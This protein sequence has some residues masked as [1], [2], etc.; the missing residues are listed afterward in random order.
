MYLFGVIRYVTVRGA[1]FHNRKRGLVDDL[2]KLI[3]IREC[4][5][6]DARHRVGDRHAREA[7]AFVERILTDARHRVGDRHAREATAFV[8]RLV[9]NAR[10]GVG[11]R[12][13][14]DF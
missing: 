2:D 1:T 6:T 8:E 3:T 9:T 7:R 14:N 10:H 5:V 13:F 4:R 11:D 12:N